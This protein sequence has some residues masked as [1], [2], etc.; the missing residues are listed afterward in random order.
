MAERY[1]NFVSDQSIPK[2]LSRQILIEA[3]EKDKMLSEIKNLINDKLHVNVGQ[4]KKIKDELS[5]TSDGLVLRGNRIICAQKWLHSVFL[6]TD[7]THFSAHATLD[8]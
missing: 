3:T 6:L 1:V 7:K 2:A 8:R 4:Y 5:I